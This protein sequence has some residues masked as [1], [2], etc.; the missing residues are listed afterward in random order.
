MAEKKAVNPHGLT[1]F[2]KPARNTESHRQ[3]CG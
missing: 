2:E 3:D 1:A